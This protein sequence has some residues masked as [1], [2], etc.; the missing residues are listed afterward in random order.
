MDIIEICQATEEEREW[1]AGLM[2][3]SDPWITLRRGLKACRAA[4]S[5]PEIALFVAHSGTIP[6]GFIRLQERGVAGSPYVASIE[7]APDYRGKGIGSRLLQFAEEF[8]RREHRHIFLC[9]SS[10]NKRARDLYE[11]VGYHAV[12]ELQ[13]YIIDGA[14]EILMHKRL[15]NS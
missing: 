15:R 6:C 3:N 2:A 9:V 10:F 11:R 12:G 8:Y 1:A 14:S 13:D 7:V 4:C 5:Q